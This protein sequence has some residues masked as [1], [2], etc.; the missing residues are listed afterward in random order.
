MRGFDHDGFGLDD[1]AD[2]LGQVLNQH[3]NDLS[4][5]QRDQLWERQQ[6][7]QQ[8]QQSGNPSLAFGG[9]DKQGFMDDTLRMAGPV[10]AGYMMRMLQDRITGRGQEPRAAAADY[11]PGRD[12]PQ[13]PQYGTFQQ[14]D[15]VYRSTSG[16][17]SVEETD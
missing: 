5:N 9:Q 16:G 1:V 13:R 7:I 11:D 8:A 14:G 15:A 2:I 4:S 10:V 6:R 3:G 17:Q 12:V